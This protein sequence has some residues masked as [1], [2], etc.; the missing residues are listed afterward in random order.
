[1]TLARVQTG[2]LASARVQ[3]GIL[4]VAMVLTGTLAVARVQTGTLASSDNW[5]SQSHAGSDICHL[6]EIDF[7]IMHSHGKCRAMSDH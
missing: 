1:M 5:R 4:A 7:N 2:T 3:T 6:H